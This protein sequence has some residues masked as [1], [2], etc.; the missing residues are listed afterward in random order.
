MRVWIGGNRIPTVR[1]NGTQNKRAQ[2]HTIGRSFA[3]PYARRDTP[4]EATGPNTTKKK[5]MISIYNMATPTSPV[6]PFPS[7]HGCP[8][9]GLCYR[10]QL[11]HV[12]SLRTLWEEETDEL[13]LA[14]TSDQGTPFCPSG[15]H[16]SHHQRWH[17][18]HSRPCA[19]DSQRGMKRDARAGLSN[20]LLSM[21]CW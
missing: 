4:R 5:G 6:R 8:R 19:H 3:S 7:G 21:C 10:R 15:M 13:E 11:K 20:T 16:D 14:D 2:M 1:K 9:L 18:A 12:P 17:R